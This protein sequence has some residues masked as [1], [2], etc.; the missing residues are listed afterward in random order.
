MKIPKAYSAAE[1]VSFFFWVPEEQHGEARSAA[2]LKKLG[3]LWRVFLAKFWRK[4]RVIKNYKHRLD[5]QRVPLSLSHPLCE[6]PGPG[7]QY[8]KLLLDPGQ[9]PSVRICF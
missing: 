3:W 6:N 2:K 9:L 1:G 4:R 7:L 5:V 8:L